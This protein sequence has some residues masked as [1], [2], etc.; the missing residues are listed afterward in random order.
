MA[1]VVHQDPPAGGAG[2][3]PQNPPSFEGTADPVVAKE[4][5]SILERIFDFIGTTEHENVWDAAKKG[6]NVAEM[7]WPELLVFF[8][9]KYY[10]CTVIDHKVVE[11]MTLKQ[12]NLCIQEYTRKFDHLCRFTP[13]MVNTESTK[14]W[15]FMRGL[16]EEMG[17]LVDTGKT[18]LETYAEAVERA[19]RQ[20]SWSELERK[21][22]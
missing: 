7:E 17:K 10:S 15:R 2:D 8:N 9:S 21:E 22:S 19:L 18:S 12:G 5:I 3:E 4:W 1:K 14:V 13:D 16:R 11:F 6:H 20:E